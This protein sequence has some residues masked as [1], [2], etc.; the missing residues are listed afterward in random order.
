MKATDISLRQPGDRESKGLN[1]KHLWAALRDPL[2]ASTITISRICSCRSLTFA[3]GY[4]PGLCY[5]GCNVCFAS[6]PLFVP[7]IISQMGAFSTIQ[8]NGLSA[9][10]FFL[11]WIVICSVAWISDRI[12]VRGPIVALFG[13]V[14]ATGYIILGTTTGVA[15]RYFALFLSVLIF[16]SVAHLLM[17]VGNNHATDSRRAA[18]L[19]ILATMGQCGPV[20][21]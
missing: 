4:L 5:F 2:C 16:V 13:L 21:G 3:T 17:W 6:L 1:A 18:G 7:T 10:P 8:S 9:P 20:L 12:G 15:P 11:C 14:G 19:G